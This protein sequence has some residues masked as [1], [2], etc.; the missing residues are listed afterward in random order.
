MHGNVSPLDG[1]RNRR[2]ASRQCYKLP[3]AYIH[4]A[5]NSGLKT[6][7][8]KSEKKAWKFRFDIVMR[9]LPFISRAYNE[10]RILKHPYL[11][12]LHLRK[13]CQVETVI[14]PSKRN[15]EDEFCEIS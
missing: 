8:V 11:T 6:Y 7:N 3:T 14:V 10:L 4:Q 12:H 9:I 2:L 13:T 15:F 5:E 1:L